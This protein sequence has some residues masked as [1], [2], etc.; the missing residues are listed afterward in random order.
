[1]GLSLI[2]I[3]IS[4]QRM[5]EIQALVNVLDKIMLVLNIVQGILIMYFT[6]LATLTLPK[7]KIPTQIKRAKSFLVS[8]ALSL[9]WLIV[10]QGT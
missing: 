7:L 1:M 2:K 6:V 5:M 9:S 8:H 10:S 3:N 4:D